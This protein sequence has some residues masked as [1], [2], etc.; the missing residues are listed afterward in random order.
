MS[1]A[2]TTASR[3]EHVDRLG[4]WLDNELAG[5]AIPPLLVLIGLGDGALLEAIEARTQGARVLALEPDPRR[6]RAVLASPVYQAWRESG[7]LVYLADPDY[8]GADQAWRIFAAGLTVPTVLLHPETVMNEGVARASQRLKKILFGVA[9][10]AEARRRFAPRYLINAIRNLPAIV[11]GSNISHLADAYRG[12]PAVVAGAGPSLDAVIPALRKL[13]N[14]A[15]VIAA[16]TALRPLAAAGITPSLVVAL[17]PSEVNARHLLSLPPCRDTWLVSEAALD[18]Q[19]AAVFDRRT[20]WFRASD[21]HP[22]P[23]FREHGIDPGHLD[24]WGSVLTGAF[25]LA[26]LAGCDPIVL[27][28]A[29]L[30]FTDNRPYARGTTYEADWA[31]SVAAGA[32]LDDLWKAAT[33]AGQPVPDVRGGTTLATPALVSFRDWMIAQAA[34]SGRRVVNATGAGIIAGPG[35]EQ[36]ALEDVL[37]QPVAI[38]PV[39][40]F[41]RRWSGVRPTALAAQVRKVG[42]ALNR[43]SADPLIASWQTFS[44]EGFNAAEVSA[45]LA[46][47]VDGLE[48]R[49]GAPASSPHDLWADPDTATVLRDLLPRLPEAVAQ[50]PAG[51]LFTPP[52]ETTAPSPSR[53]SEGDRA[54]SLVRAWEVLA[55]ICNT[56][57]H[58]EADLPAPPDPAA[59][60]Y[61]RTSA[62]YA[63]PETARWSVAVFDGLLGNAWP[64]A[65]EAKLPFVSRMLLPDGSS[66]GP[67]P[68][69]NAARACALLVLEWLRCAGVSRHVWTALASS[70]RHEALNGSPTAPL[71][72]VETV[73]PNSSGDVDICLT[74][75]TSAMTMFRTGELHSADCV[76]RSIPTRLDVATVLHLCGVNSPAIFD[77]LTRRRPHVASSRSAP[78]HRDTVRPRVLTRGRA[79][80]IWVISYRTEDG[81]VCVPHHHSG[82]I[83][84]AADGSMRPHLAWPRPITQECPFGDEGVLAWGNGYASPEPVAPYVMYRATPSAEVAIEELPFRPAF[85]TWWRGRMYWSSFSRGEQWRGLVSWAPGEPMRVER[86][87]ITSWAMNADDD[88]L[89]IQPCTFVPPT[90]WQRGTSSRGWKLGP[91]GAIEPYPL[92]LHGSLSSTDTHHQWTATAYPDS[93]KVLLESSDGRSITLVCPSPLRVSWTDGSLLVSTLPGELLLFERL[94]EVLDA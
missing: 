14:R 17:D 60:G 54:R 13:Q 77:E 56:T 73:K 32:S 4:R 5:K 58:A 61:A 35:I 28:G 67:M 94:L 57:L 10:N 84:I 85:G 8:I 71:F 29:D 3:R 80:D 48:T 40:S 38:A 43:G 44:G 89:V 65:Q 25:R 19:A 7:R 68:R 79:Q 76:S 9:A 2:P 6:A 30:S 18:P 64:P 59:I 78:T 1:T 86:E 88:S 52:P 91:E 63:W 39:S 20:F 46:A 41:A 87:G 62:V 90:G 49:R 26:C 81:V 82:S 74:F 33:S 45:A 93:D 21:H 47:A 83:L 92:P 66:P 34:A 53:A 69:P 50:V 23:W 16:D 72:G 36:A 15:L 27:V 12:V 51:L 75:G 22:G 70:L 31:R 11:A 55:R 37:T 42:A 24:V